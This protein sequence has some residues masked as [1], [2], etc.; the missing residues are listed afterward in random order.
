MSHFHYCNA[1]KEDENVFFRNDSLRRLEAG[2]TLLPSDG[3][4]SDVYRKLLDDIQR[5]GVFSKDNRIIVPT[6]IPHDEFHFLVLFP[7]AKY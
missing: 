6:L 4:L 3:S 5:E 7:M 2:D 1:F